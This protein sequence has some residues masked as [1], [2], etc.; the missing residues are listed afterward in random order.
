M[1][2]DDLARFLN[3]QEPVRRQV[4]DEL[5]AG[6]KRSHWMW[7]VFPQL[8]GLGHSPN[9]YFYGLR[10]RDE[11]CRYLAHPTLG[12]RLR[13]DVTLMLTHADKSAYEIL[14]WP[15]KVKFRSC[16]TLFLHAAETDDDKAL[17]A[18]ALDRFYGGEEDPRT[19]ALL[20]DV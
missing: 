11:A 20:D 5:K 16:L 10:D 2:E 18:Q 8:R 13:H 6:R 17:F 9:A 3:A 19:L 15:D 1:A 14:G 7:F 12:E 4:L